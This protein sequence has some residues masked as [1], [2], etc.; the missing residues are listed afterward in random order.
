MM[1][2]GWVSRLMRGVMW[3][4]P[5]AA[6]L[7]THCS[8]SDIRDALVSAGLDFVQDS[9]SQVL[10]TLIPVEEIMGGN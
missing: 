5:G 7:G 4:V 10:S 1:K 2:S 3:L 8:A 6:V 9:A